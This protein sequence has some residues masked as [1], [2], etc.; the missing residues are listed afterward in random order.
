MDFMRPTRFLIP[1]LAVVLLASGGSAFAQRYYDPP[2]VQHWQ[3]DAERDLEHRGFQD[4]LV[5][6]DRDFQNH[7]RPDVNNRDEYRDPRFI[8]GWAQHEYRE[9]FRRG[10]YQRVRQIYRGGDGPGYGYR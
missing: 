4:G 10:Y 8:P 3:G 5:G 2:P 1:T 7:R 9:G 6:A